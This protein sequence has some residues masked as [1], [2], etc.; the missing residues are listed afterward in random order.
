MLKKK[1]KLMKVDFLVSKVKKWNNKKCINKLKIKANKFNQSFINKY[2]LWR[3][4]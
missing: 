4:R 1:L 2:L 3:K